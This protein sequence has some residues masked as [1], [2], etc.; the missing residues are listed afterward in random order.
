MLHPA[1]HRALRELHATTRQLRNHWRKLGRWLDSEYLTQVADHAE[2][3]LSE[4]EPRLDADYDLHGRPAAQALGA[5]FAGARGATDVLLERNQAL[6][7]ALLDLQHVVTLLDYTRVLA[8]ARDDQELATFLRDWRQALE[9]FEPRG[10]S[11]VE[12]LAGDPDAAIA[13]AQDSPVG[14]A[15]VKVGVALGALGEAIDNSRFGRLS[16]RRNT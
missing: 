3:L 14:R 12:A 7:A 10:R 6:R 8:L 9:P 5:R 11:L 15:G 13:P 2:H 16:R 4:L 1:E